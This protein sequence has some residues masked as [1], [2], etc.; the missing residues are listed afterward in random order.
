M[1]IADFSMIKDSLLK[2][3]NNISGDTIKIKFSNN[4]I[5][6]MDIIGGV[7][8]KFIPDKKNQEI[9]NTIFYEANTIDYEMENENGDQFHAAIPTFKLISPQSI[10]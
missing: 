4:L 9:S 8:G 10:N 6:K 2:G 7:K 1:A 5:Q 3:L